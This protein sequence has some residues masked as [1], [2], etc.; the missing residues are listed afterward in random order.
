MLTMQDDGNLVLYDT[1]NTPIW[2]TGTNQFQNII[3][4]ES[5]PL[6]M[7]QALTS[8]NRIYQ[9]VMQTD[10]NF[11]VYHGTTA[12]WATGTTGPTSNG[13]PN[14]SPYE[15]VLTPD[16]DLEHLAY[17]QT[18]PTYTPCIANWSS[19]SKGKGTPPYKLTMQD[20]GNLVRL[21]QHQHSNLGHRHVRPQSSTTDREQ[22]KEKFDEEKQIPPQSSLW[23]ALGVSGPWANPRTRSSARRLPV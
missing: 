2:A 10:G 23:L 19:N 20:D 11:V 17:G 18:C 4:S 7:G 3:T 1:T 16:G 5:A 12:L 8:P 6:M 22:A 9:A 13:S 14:G 21:R 15:M